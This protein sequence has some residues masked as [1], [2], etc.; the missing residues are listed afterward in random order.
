[1]WTAVLP[2]DY[3]VVVIDMMS[4]T[5]SYLILAPHCLRINSTIGQLNQLCF[6]CNSSYSTYVL[7]TWYCCSA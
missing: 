4:A 3:F 2:T 5:Y 6:H 1:L 7:F